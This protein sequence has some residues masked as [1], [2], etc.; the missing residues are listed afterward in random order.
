M[1]QALESGH[2]GRSITL[3]QR[4]HKHH[5]NRLELILNESRNRL[6]LLLERL[7][8]VRAQIQLFEDLTA[9][10]ATVKNAVKN[11]VA[12]LLNSFVQRLAFDA[13]DSQLIDHMDIL[14]VGVPAKNRN[15]V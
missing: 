12:L 11:S 7:L 8:T 15:E 13:F 9:Q 4:C 10:F 3:G 5:R 14:F 1:N 2:L 6:V